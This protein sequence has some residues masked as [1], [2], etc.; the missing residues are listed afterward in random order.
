TLY[1]S[2]MISNSAVKTATPALRRAK[3]VCTLGP[4]TDPAERLA[5]LL[6]AGMNVAQ[7]GTTNLLR[8]HRIKT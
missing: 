5:A 6:D 2:S 3:I 1:S 4:L 8:T 7:R